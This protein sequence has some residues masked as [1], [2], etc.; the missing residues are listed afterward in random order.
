VLDSFTLAVQD[1]FDVELPRDVEWGSQGE[2]FILSETG[3]LYRRYPVVLS[4]TDPDLVASGLDN[5]WSMTWAR[6]GPIIS[7]ISA[8]MWWDSRVTPRSGGAFGTLTLHSP[9]I[10]DKSQED[11]QNL[12]LRCS[13]SSV[14]QYFIHD[15]TP[16]TQVVWRDET[17]PSRV[18]EVSA[19]SSGSTF[20]Y[21]PNPS[22]N[23][24]ND[25]VKRAFH[26]RIHL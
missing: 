12:T 16:D 2:L 15:K 17:R 5:S 11:T 19:E 21:S 8:R 9:W 25:E 4:D 26:K 13:A 23:L 7:D 24:V 20:Y 22:E 3:R 14:F 1:A 6:G 18:L 10:D